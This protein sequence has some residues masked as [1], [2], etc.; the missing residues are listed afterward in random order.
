VTN[1]D[2][3]AE[4][5]DLL[6]LSGRVVGVDDRLSKRTS[7]RVGIARWYMT[8]RPVPEAA[9]PWRIPIQSSADLRNTG[10]LNR[11]ADCWGRD[12]SR[13]PLTAEDGRTALRLM[14]EVVE[15]NDMKKTSTQRRV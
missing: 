5:N 3:L 8:V 15:A 2:P 9:D 12:D 10:Y 7:R 6:R 14:H 4:L 13:P 11:W 1:T